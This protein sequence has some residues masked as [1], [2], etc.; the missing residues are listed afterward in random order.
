[1]LVNNLLDN[2]RRKGCTNKN[3][4]LNT[5]LYFGTSKIWRMLGLEIRRDLKLVK[6]SYE[7]GSYKKGMKRIFILAAVASVGLSACNKT[8]SF[9]NRLSGEVWQATKLTIDGDAEEADHLPEL[10]FD[11]CDIYDFGVQVGGARKGQRFRVP[12]FFNWLCPTQA[13]NIHF[14]SAKTML[15]LEKH[16][17]I[18]RFNYSLKLCS[19][20]RVFVTA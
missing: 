13:K 18:G 10:H 20:C 1:M 19:C 6:V 5:R 2:C 11:D 16:Y 7:V 14:A 17:F 12:R 15:M 8:N 3:L 4:C 9:S